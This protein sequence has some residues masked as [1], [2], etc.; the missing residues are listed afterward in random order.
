M[1]SRPRWVFVLLLLGA[2]RSASAQQPTSGSISGTVVDAAGAALVGVEVRV[3]SEQ[4]TREAR[5]G[6]GG[7]FLVPHLPPGHYDVR[8]ALAGFA[9][10]ERSDVDLRLGQRLAFDFVM[11]AGE[12]GDVLEVEGSA[13]ILDLSS[14]SVQT[15]LDSRLLQTLPVGRRLGDSLGLAAGVSS[16]G[17]TGRSN[18]SIAGASGLE[19][20][21]VVDGVSVGNPRYGTLGVFHRDYG[22]LGSGVTNEFIDEVQVRSAGAEAEEAQSSGG[23]VN[24]VTKSGSNVWRGAAFAYAQL[25]ALEGRWRRVELP[26]GS[27]NTTG[28]ESREVGFT[29]GGPVAKDRAFFFVALDPQQE[30][31]R[32]VAPE[33]YP[34]RELGT[35]DR[36]RDLTA[37]AAKLTLQPT[38]RHRF[39]LSFFGDPSDSEMGPQSAAAMAA[40]STG[41]FSAL[42]YGGHNQ[43]LRYQGTLS[44][45][46]L[47]EASLG[48]AQS[49]LRETP[50]ID[51]WQVTDFT[52]TPSTSSGGKGRFESDG[53]GET[54]QYQVRSTLL[55]G[56]HELKL[57][58]SREDASFD[59]GDNYTGPP[60]VLRNGVRLGSGV[61]VNVIS[62]P[63]YGRVYRVVAG[64]EQTARESWDDSSSLFVQD[65]LV[66]SDRL[67]LSAGLRYERQEVGGPLGSFTFDDNWSPRLGLAVDPSGRGRSKLFASAGVYFSR[68]PNNLPVLAFGGSGIR[69]LRADYFDPEL[70]QPIPDGTQA[71]GTAA[72][73]VVGQTQ[74]SRFDPEAKLGYVREATAG[75]ESEVMP[76]LT[77]GARV[78][79]RDMPRMLEDIGTASLVLLVSGDPAARAVNYVIGN[80]HDGY[81]ATAGGVGSF[82]TLTHRYRALELTAEKRFADRWSLLASYRW[83]RLRG[84]Y[85]GFYRNDTSQAT[86]GQTSLFDF[87]M[88][89]PSYRAI[90][91]PLYGFSGDI[92]Y[93]GALGAGPLPNDRTH[94]VKVHGTY[95]FDFGLAL[96]AGLTAG[97][98]RPLTPMAANPVTNRR[99]DIPEAPRGSG[100]ETVDGLET[101]TPF[102]WSVDL[103]ADYPIELSRVRL[104]LVLDVFNLFDA[105]QVTGYDQDT[106]L[107]FRVANPNYGYRTAYQDPRSVR[108]G[109]RFEL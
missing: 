50:A 38:D 99:G 42:D 96:G 31:T 22:A 78:I 66:A 24:V 46:W 48:R 33:G 80:P 75:I 82:E 92:R 8:L 43:A 41:A 14:A 10:V 103:H 65:R 18:P 39:D 58:A 60:I 49:Y 25:E 74:P 45:R 88:N 69:V 53:E 52:A 54:W 61:V 9:T 37:Y 84:S 108:L 106:Q 67:T 102:E 64:R 5:T 36:T 97:S 59:Y 7:K 83:S 107:G 104:L 30:T 27:G 91:V 63:V 87:P 2:I 1:S 85:E 81:P 17:G 86:P 13:P 51:E 68:V 94:E 55:L 15:T 95:A 29:L 35:V 73:L 109:I 19:N 76:R 12:F 71:G 21:Y 34:L 79:Y 100:I 105:R 6:A 98:G 23:V 44:A 3:A 62:D 89:D 47:V 70:T 16:G 11:A 26:N 72:H 90:G 4:G 101:R 93:Q 57:G 32:F 56:R 28:S 77:L 40:K 20:Q